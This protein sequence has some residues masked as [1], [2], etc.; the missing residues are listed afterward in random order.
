MQSQHSMPSSI[1]SDKV[2]GGA[3]LQIQERMQLAGASCT[4]CTL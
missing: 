3:P 4:Y 1:V 2:Q